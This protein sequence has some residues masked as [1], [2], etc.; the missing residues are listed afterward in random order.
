MATPDHQAPATVVKVGGSLFDLPDLGARLR[1]WLDG[2]D[3]PTVLLVPGGGPTADVIRDLDRRHRLGEE[4]SHW[5]ALRAL[6]LNAA[7]LQAL[8]PGTEVVGDLRDVGAACHRGRVPVLDAHPFALADEGRPGRL[9]HT[10]AVTGD[11]VAA[12]VALVAGARQLILLKSVT[13]PADVD[14]LEAGRR[15]LV[16]A[17]LGVVLGAAAP[18]QVKAINFRAWHP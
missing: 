15:G 16:D 2:L 5:L 11:A 12:R 8:V 9:P 18:I 6:A 17:Y 13:I 1:A 4:T 14:W 10:W 3:S 7:V